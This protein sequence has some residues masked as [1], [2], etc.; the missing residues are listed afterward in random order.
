MTDVKHYGK[1]VLNVLT[2]LSLKLSS[3]A[4][5]IWIDHHLRTTQPGTIM[6]PTTQLE[7]T[8]L[9]VSP[10]LHPMPFRIDFA[11]QLDFPLFGKMKAAGLR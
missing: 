5:A 10:T 6:R 11:G 4:A 7:I 8:L 3:A 9:N 1:R 2:A